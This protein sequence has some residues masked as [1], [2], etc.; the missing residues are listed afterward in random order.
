[1]RTI[2]INSSNLVKGTKNKFQ[3]YFPTPWSA[4]RGSRI[5]LQSIS[6]YNSTF[7]IK[8]AY[9]NNIFKIYF[10]DTLYTWTIPSGYYSASDL[11][12]WLQSQFVLNGL[13]AVQS[14]GSFVYFAEIIENPPRYSI[15]LNVYP[16]INSSGYSLPDGS[17]LTL[18][19]NGV[20]PQVEIS[21]GLG[22]L[23]G[24]PVGSLPAQPSANPMQFV[25]QDYG[26][27]PI[28]SPVDTYVLRCNM[29]SSPLS[30]PSDGFFQVPLSAGL[31]QLI[32]QSVSTLSFVSIY[33]TIYRYIEILLCDQFFNP[34][35]NQDTSMTL[36]IVIDDGQE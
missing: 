12:N 24:L 2:I 31:G 26:L 15:Q 34:L 8:P 35:E 22:S 9:G 33:P 4:P 6:I 25:S 20:T 14:N 36:S 23:L 18:S 5:A 11:N 27:A 13:Y 16:L 17:N 21:A 7:N 30:N 10:G 19:D 32:S 3:Y 29:V 1:M 28:L